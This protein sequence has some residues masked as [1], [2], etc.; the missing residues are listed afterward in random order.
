MLLNEQSSDGWLG[1]SWRSVG[2]TVITTPFRYYKWL[3]LQSEIVDVSLVQVIACRLF[4]AK[5]L[6]EP[7]E[8]PVIWNVMTAMLRHCNNKAAKRDFGI[9]NDYISNG[10]VWRFALLLAGD[11]I[12]QTVE[13]VVIGNIKTLMWRHC[14]NNDISVLPMTTSPLR[15]CGCFL[16]YRQGHTAGVQ[17]S[18]WVFETSWRPVCITVITML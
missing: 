4:G 3:H 14:N 12:E 17:S 1:T 11:A 8:R 7:V 15:E 18:G 16:C 6:P 5:P 9:T 13:Q 2:I 10:R